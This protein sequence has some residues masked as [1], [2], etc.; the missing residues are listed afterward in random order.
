MGSAVRRCGSAGRG[1]DGV[2][3]IQR[4]HS[5]GEGG[6][7][8]GG[9]FV[10][11]VC[12]VVAWTAGPGGFGDGELARWGGC[13]RRRS[14]VEGGW[15]RVDGGGLWSKLGLEF[16]SPGLELLPWPGR[17]RV[18]VLSNFWWRRCGMT[19]WPDQHS[20]QRS[21][22]P[23]EHCMAAIAELRVRTVAL[24]RQPG[25]RRVCQGKVTLVSS[26]G[27]RLDECMPR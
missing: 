5:T 14:R 4:Q 22:R 23:S 15:W 1:R 6:R 13:R 18:R 9:L 11:G 2:R 17:G 19:D 27:P 21:H 3:A 12:S 24:E 26:W 16:E 8:G 25:R 7:K 20:S 10:G